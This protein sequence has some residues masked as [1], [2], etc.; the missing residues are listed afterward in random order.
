MRVRSVRAIAGDRDVDELR[1]YL[2][3]LLVAKAVLLCRARAKVLTEDI[4]NSD[5][6]AQDLATLRCLE[7]DGDALDTAVVGLEE[8]ARMSR[9][10]R[11]RSE[12][13][14]VGKEGRSQW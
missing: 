5:E 3:Q 13:R 7:I 9:Q 14:R 2:F 1:V 4:R 10:H 12:E 8:R 6:L 11:G